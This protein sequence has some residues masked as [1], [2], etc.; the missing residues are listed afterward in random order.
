MTID[1]KENGERKNLAHLTDLLIESKFSN[2]SIC[3]KARK[4]DRSENFLD[5]YGKKIVV[6]NDYEEYSC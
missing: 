3:S 5:Q 1:N 4:A 6:V 2:F